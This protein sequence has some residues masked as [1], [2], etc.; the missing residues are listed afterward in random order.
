M[1]IILIYSNDTNNA[2]APQ[3]LDLDYS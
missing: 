3:T 1:L 2:D